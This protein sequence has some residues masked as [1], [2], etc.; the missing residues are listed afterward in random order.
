MRTSKIYLSLFFAILD[1]LSLFVIYSLLLLRK[2]HRDCFH[3]AQEAMNSMK[4]ALFRR[5]NERLGQ[6]NT[7]PRCV[8]GLLQSNLC[9]SMNMCTVPETFI[10]RSM[11]SRKK[12]TPQS[13]S[14]GFIW[15]LNLAFALSHY[16]AN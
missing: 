11:K 1:I 4:Q 6:L 2:L 3:K 10:P 15:L 13:E 8:S 16:D 12:F 7:K 14:D 9:N 5:Y